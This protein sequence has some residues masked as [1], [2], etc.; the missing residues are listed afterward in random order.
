M[1][2]SFLGCVGLW[3]VVASRMRSYLS[4]GGMDADYPAI[5]GFRFFFYSLEGSEP[6]HVH[7]EHG[8]SIA[9]FWLNPVSLAESRGFRSHELTRL[10]ILV[11]EHRQR[12]L[13]AWNVHFGR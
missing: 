9:K 1:A 7:I 5:S 13:E 2:T 4:R 11:I 12:L 3:R 8:D 6:A 10:R